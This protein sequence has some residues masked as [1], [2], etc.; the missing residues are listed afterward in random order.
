MQT[1]YFDYLYSKVLKVE[2]S[3]DEFDEYLYDRDCGPGD[4]QRAIDS[5]SKVKKSK[6]KARE[7]MAK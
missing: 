1:T 4:A 2:L 3:G 6:K 5:I 7:K